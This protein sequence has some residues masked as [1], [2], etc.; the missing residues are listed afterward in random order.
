MVVR[1]VDI[2]LSVSFSSDRKDS[3]ILFFLAPLK[4]DL[5]TYSIRLNHY[6]QPNHEVILH[7]SPRTFR[8]LPGFLKCIC[9][10]I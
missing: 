1:Y 9:H 6:H 5:G 7:H 2:D 10:Y 3:S 4:R 8:L